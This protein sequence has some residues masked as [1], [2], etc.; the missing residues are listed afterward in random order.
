MTPPPPLAFRARCLSCFLGLMALTTTL[1]F[2]QSN[3]ARV[4]ARDASGTPTVILGKLGLLS[5]L[6]PPAHKRQSTLAR[7]ASEY[8]A[9]SPTQEA[10]WST[11]AHRAARAHLNATG[12]EQFEVR[13]ARLDDGG[14]LHVRLAQT[15]GSLQ[16]D[17]GELILH[18]RARTGEVYAINGNF[19]PARGQ[20]REPLVTSVY[21]LSRALTEYEVNQPELAHDAQLVYLYDPENGTELAWRQTVNYEHED[22]GA[23]VEERDVIYASAIDG[24]L[25]AAE[26][27]IQRATEIKT[28]DNENRR[29][30][31][32]PG[33]LLCTNEQ[34]CSH[35]VAQDA[36]DNATRVYEYYLKNFGRDSWDDQG[37]T[38]SSSVH[39]CEDW[40][41]ASF[42]GEHMLFGDGDTTGD[43][44]FGGSVS[45]PLGGALDVVAHE[46]THGVIRAHSNLKYKR[47]AESGDINEAWADIFG[48]SAEA[49]LDG[50]TSFATWQLAE[51]VW[52]PGIVGG[53]LR[54]L[55]DPQLDGTSIDHY[56]RRITSSKRKHAAMH[57]NSG[58]GRLA[59]HLLVEGGQHPRESNGWEVKAIGIERAQQIFYRAQTEYLARKSRW[60]DVRWATA[61]VA[62]DLYRDRLVVNQV[63]RAW[64]A[65]G[66]P[67]CPAGIS[68][69]G[70]ANGGGPS[71][72]L[73]V[74][75]LREW[76]A[77]G[78]VHYESFEFYVPPG[79]SSL[80]VHTLAGT[81][82][83]NIAL[84]LAH[85]RSATLDSFDFRSNAS[86]NEEQILVASPRPGRWQI[87]IAAM[88]SFALDGLEASFVPAPR[89][90]LRER[91]EVTGLSGRAGATQFFEVNLS[92]FARRFHVR[93]FGGTGDADLFVRRG[94]DPTRAD[95]DCRPYLASND[96]L[97][98]V[99]V[100]APGR[101][102]IAVRAGTG[103]F[104]DATLQTHA[105]GAPTGCS[106]PALL[107]ETAMSS[108]GDTR[109][110]RIF[111][112]ACARELEVRTGNGS[113]DADLLVRYGS[114]PTA[115]TAECRP[116]LLGN[117]ERCT[118]PVTTPGE[119]VIQ[120]E[121]GTGYQGVDLLA[122]YR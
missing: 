53:A 2:A 27:T 8:L 105:L 96:E 100:A 110:F 64:C 94:N 28:H 75:P 3:E 62:W 48:A 70:P 107:Q 13:Q 5:P 82:E 120:V 72:M 73:V 116:F 61:Q 12:E 10:E 20:E 45:D 52:T 50:D 102:V 103:G 68:D 93:L 16:V 40:V 18:V 84:L 41:G 76:V 92:R 42:T 67:N 106:D 4:V 24:R 88:D 51:D 109:E 56:D 36:H 22:H 115:T 1:L 44:P 101:Y 66:V 30:Q 25:L 19:A 97:C 91:D 29:R 85:Q 54:S 26:A 6:A 114:S 14:N 121:T 119:Y 49:W 63:E 89:Q 57:R 86:G 112:P 21:A 90:E 43:L 104:R 71:Q 87:S 122:S 108:D 17:G 39:V 59:F 58:I 117:E 37:A 99:Q 33:Q 60:E 78:T 23:W 7:P 38:V 47:G 69:P 55:S 118:L 95:F 35:A 74:G 77:P 81:N 9:V 98:E 32:A 31:K 79:A 113:G 65:V 15:I 34:T 83:G 46:F 80:R 111:V 11:A